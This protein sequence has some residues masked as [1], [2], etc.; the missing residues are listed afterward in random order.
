VR[1]FYCNSAILVQIIGQQHQRW[2]P[3]FR[4]NQ[5]LINRKQI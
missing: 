3:R 4:E 2:E 1:T 5:M